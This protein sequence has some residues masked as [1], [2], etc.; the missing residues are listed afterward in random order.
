MKRYDDQDLERAL[1]ALDLEEPP[2][3]LRQSILA[4]TIYRVPVAA[5]VPPWEVWLYGALCAA[6]VWLLIFVLRGSGAHEVASA[7]SIGN[8]AL[9]FF[10][11]PGTLFWIAL[12]G[13]A[14]FWISQLNLTGAAG[15]QRATRR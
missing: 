13:G 5:S 14:T 9:A 15:Y 2:A 10:S 1:F 6:M 3:D 4:S 12:G 11:Q 7:E 8:Q